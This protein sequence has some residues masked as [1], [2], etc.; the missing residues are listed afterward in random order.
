MTEAEEPIESLGSVGTNAT[1]IPIEPGSPVLQSEGLDT[2][3]YELKLSLDGLLVPL[4]TTLETQNSEV[5]FLFNEFIYT[6]V[7]S[8]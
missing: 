6:N 7:L 5:K 2:K 4:R 3:L 8:F 1:N